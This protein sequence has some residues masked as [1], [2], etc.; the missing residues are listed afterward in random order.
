MLFKKLAGLLFLLLL[1]HSCTSAPSKKSIRTGPSYEQ[2]MSQVKRIGIISDVCIARDAVGTE[3]YFSIEDSKTARAF[4]SDAAKKYLE[5]KGYQIDFQ[6][7][8][9]VCA[10]KEPDKVFK[11]AESKG[12]DVTDMSPPFFADD[13]LKD[14]EKYKQ[15]LVRVI[16]QIQ[17]SIAQLNKPHSETFLF[18]KDMQENLKEISERTSIEVILFLIGDGIIVPRG[19]SF[20]KG[21]PG[22]IL[23]PLALPI[24]LTFDYSN[25]HSYAVMINVKNGDMLWSNSFLDYDINPV[26]QD[27]YYKEWSR[28]MFYYLH[29]NKE[30]RGVRY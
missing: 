8:P 25:V 15:Q 30:D 21:L 23:L 6:F 26:N 24:Y 27:Y 1:I 20:A 28:K 9:F 10:F 11:V 14:D 12:K 7:S 19:K 4:M 29:N 16:R 17:N 5:G 13:S 3:D 2:Y 22:A 18:E